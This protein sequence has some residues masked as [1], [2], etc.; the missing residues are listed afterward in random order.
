MGEIINIFVGQYG[1]Q[2]GY[3]YMQQICQE[4]NINSFGEK[5]TQHQDDRENIKCF[6]NEQQKEKY[7]PRCVFLDLDATPIDEVRKK[8]GKLFRKDCLISG[9]EDCGS[10]CVRGKYTLGKE[11]ID[12]AFDQIRLE[13]DKCEKLQGFIIHRSINGGTGAGVGSLIADRLQAFYKKQFN[14]NSIL[15]PSNNIANEV[16]EPFNFVLGLYDITYDMSLLFQNE[17]I[18][19]FTD[20]FLDIDQPDYQ[21]INQLI[22]IINSSITHSMRFGGDLNY[23][24]E[25][26]VTNLVCYPRINYII[27]SYCSS[28]FNFIKEISGQP[29]INMLCGNLFNKQNFLVD[30]NPQKDKYL[31]CCLTARGDIYPR[32]I[33]ETI[34]ILKSK[35]SINF[36][37]YV[38]T[39]IKVG[40]CQNKPKNLLFQEYESNFQRDAILL[41]NNTSISSIF[42]NMAQKFDKLYDKRAFVHWYVGEG[43]ESDEFACAREELQALIRDY[44]EVS[45]ESNENII[46][47][48]ED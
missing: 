22:S 18:Y 29:T 17:Q 37:D 8:G 30:C 47:D 38:P 20:N 15:F 32:Q 3:E 28:N 24:M 31:S 16:V 1:V 5:S 13:A 44:E 46:E 7:V 14:I 11:I 34:K 19:Q 27:P 43:M 26:L 6:F 21:N 2:S 45:I 39:G 35:K 4:H 25:N 9:K 48:E 40:I 23:N 36:I 12:L 41:A 33:S 42:Q 10:N